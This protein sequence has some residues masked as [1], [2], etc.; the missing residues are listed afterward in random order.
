MVKTKQIHYFVMTP[1]PVL[2]PFSFVNEEA[3]G[4][5]NEEIIGVINERFIGATIAPKIP[6]IERRESCHDFN[7]IIHVSI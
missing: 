3:R 6:T 4:C 5:I 7:N 1:F 2:S